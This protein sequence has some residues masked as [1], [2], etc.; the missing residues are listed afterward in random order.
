LIAGAGEQVVPVGMG[1][2]YNGTLHPSSGAIKADRFAT[3]GLLGLG[4]KFNVFFLGVRAIGGEPRLQ[5]FSK[6]REPL[7][8]VPLTRAKGDAATPLTLKF[9][10]PAGVPA[11]QMLLGLAGG[12]EAAVPVSPLEGDPKVPSVDAV[13]GF[14]ERLGKL[15]GG[16]D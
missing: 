3:V 11:T 8:T 1:V 2:F 16:K 14:T 9:E 7:L 4:P 15:R 13:L 12:F 5:V 10:T 6:E